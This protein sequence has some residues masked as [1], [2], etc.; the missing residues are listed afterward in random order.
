MDLLSGSRISSMLDLQSSHSLWNRTFLLRTAL[1]CRCCVLPFCQ[2]LYVVQCSQ[3]KSTFSYQHAALANHGK[4][5]SIVHKVFL[6]MYSIK[7][8][9]MQHTPCVIIWNIHI[10]TWCVHVVLKN[11]TTDF[12]DFSALTYIN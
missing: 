3:W 10:S 5:L 2:W 6:C 4:K 7:R 11:S 1:Q 12:Q 8:S 9:E